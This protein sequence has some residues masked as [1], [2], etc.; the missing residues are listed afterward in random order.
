[1]NKLLNFLNY[2]RTAFEKLYFI[3]IAHNYELTITVKIKNRIGENSNNCQ[4]GS[5]YL[6]AVIERKKIP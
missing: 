4:V 6:K 2:H 3:D 5:Y 1:M